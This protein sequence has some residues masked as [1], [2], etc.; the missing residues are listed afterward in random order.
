MD[1]EDLPMSQ[2]P[3]P[4]GNP[5]PFGKPDGAVPPPAQGPPQTPPAAPPAGGYG[6]PAAATPVQPGPHTPPLPGP[7]P[8]ADNPYAAPTPPGQNPYAA[9]PAQQAF[10]QAPFPHA[11]APPP[12]AGRGQPPV[13]QQGYGHPGGQGYAQPYGQQPAPPY[14][15]GQAPPP[16]GYP[17]PYQGAPA[18]RSGNSRL[19]AIVAAAVAAVLLITGGVWLAT[20]GGGDPA[21]RPQADSGGANGGTGTAKPPTTTDLAFTWDVDAD[22]VAEKD[23][24]KDALGIWFTDRYVVKNE[25][26]KVVAYDL[27]SGT[28]AW[29]LAAPSGGDCTAARDSYDDTAAVQ[30]GADCEKVMAFDLTT[31][32][33]LW[34][35]NLPGGGGSGDYDY[36]QMAIS[37][38]VVGV[39]WLEGSIA[40]RLSDRKVMWQGGDGDCEDDGYAGGRQFVAVVDCDEKSYRVQVID[41]ADNGAAKWSWT[42]PTGTQVSA[43][44]STDPV[45]V[46]LGT[47]SEPYTDAAVVSNGRLE[48]RVSLGTD[49]YDILDDGTEQQSVHNVLV[50]SDTLY[51]SL[52]G[53]SDGNGQV[54]SGIVAFNLSDGRQKWVARPADKQDITG[55]GFQ[56]GKVLAYQ[57]PDYDVQGR[58]LTLDPATGAMSRFATFPKD[59]YDHLDVSAM[60]AYPVWHDGHFYVAD[61]TVYAS[62]SGQKYLI[63]YG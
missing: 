15:Y 23:N 44:V 27:I 11:A 13:P 35:T 28:P 58:L 12:Y 6:Y 52:R 60:R 41:T 24:L 45:V 19:L 34:S 31:G 26:D 10:P 47:E 36:T 7:V 61:K 59:A 57:P 5:P 14:G 3:P 51:L 2:P 9:A 1:E 20:K 29:T 16:G 22:T 37:N 42:A 62:S 39:D 43:I 8:A 33:S 63:C 38:G 50:S 30:Y 49:K 48:S 17:Q 4:P 53:Q 18:G 54:L 25:I 56:D 55:L 32:K 21:P 40:Y 46:L